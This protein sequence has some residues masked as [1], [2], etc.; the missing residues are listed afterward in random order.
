[1][2]PVIESKTFEYTVDHRSKRQDDE[3][4]QEWVSE[5]LELL[6]KPLVCSAV[7]RAVA[8]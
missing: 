3:S 4:M 8:S 6:S 1:M 7:G 2:P 5:Y